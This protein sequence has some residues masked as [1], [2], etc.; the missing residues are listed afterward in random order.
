MSKGQQVFL[1][2]GLME[3]GSV[4]GH[5]AYLGPDYTADY[6]R[7]SSESVR[8]SLG[9]AESDSAVQA[10]IEDMRT[11][12]YDAET[13]TLTFSEPQAAAFREL[14]P[15]YPPSSPTRR[16]CTGFAPRRS[17]TRPS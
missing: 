12:R 16:R 3:Y 7:R 1:E 5:G 9:G 13:G 8:E 4:F 17:P 14:V 15:Y 11:N 2:N 6:L 10:T